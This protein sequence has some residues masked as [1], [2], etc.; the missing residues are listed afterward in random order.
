MR[1]LAIEEVATGADEVMSAQF[2]NC[3]KKLGVSLSDAAAA[4]GA[5]IEELALIEGGHL[6][7]FADQARLRLVVLAYCDYLGFEP[8]PFLARL[9]A[10]ADWELLDPPNLFALQGPDLR[11]YWARPSVGF[12]AFGLGL[13]FVAGWVVLHMVNR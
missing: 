12:L 13:V 6:A 1:I 4:T 5:D 9:E 10:Y 2:S 7:A 11:T 8:G 3:R